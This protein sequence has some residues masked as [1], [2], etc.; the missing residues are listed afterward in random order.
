M[1]KFSTS[2]GNTHLFLVLE[3]L[4]VMLV[5]VGDRFW[6]IMSRAENRWGQ[7]RK[8]AAHKQTQSDRTKN[9]KSARS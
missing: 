5:M 7:E 3:L 2:A 4:M 6:F 8:T 1:A 9:Q